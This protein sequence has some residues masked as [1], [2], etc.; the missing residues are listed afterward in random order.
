MRLVTWNARRGAFDRKASLLD[1]LRADIAVV[2]EIAAPANESPQR[3][4]FGDNRK[5]G[6][7]VLAR[8]PYCLR[9]LP[10]LPDAPKYVV[11]IA[12]E[13]PRAFTLFAVWTLGKQAKP[14]V[15]AAA[16]AIDMYEPAFAS[17][18]V[19]MMGDFNSNSIW[20]KHHPPTLNHAAMV[21]RLERLGLVS[22]YHYH[23]RLEHGAEPKLDH[24]FYLYGH[25]DKSYHIDYC[26]LP[27]SWA[28]EIDQVSIG[29][30]NDWQAHSDH[31][32]LIVSLRD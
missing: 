30:F 17:S 5:Q 1:H 4:W 31:R 32:P 26:F 7:A 12:V 9:R 19:V 23:R 2:P 16:L 6:L 21:G 22:A 25:E 8:E 13:G 15:E 24:T 14:Y 10:E 20:N 27:R 29:N 3:L 11:P 28:K 18:P